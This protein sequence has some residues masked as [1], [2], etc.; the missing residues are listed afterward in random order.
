MFVNRTHGVVATT[1]SV[2]ALAACA[3]PEQ[4]T[5]LRPEGPPDVLAVLVMT[6]AAGQLHEE[7]TYCKLNDP[8]RP[9]LVGRPDATTAQ[10]CPED[11]GAATEV[12]NAY[13][14]GWYVR[15]MFDELL[16]PEIEELIEL[17]DADGNPSG[18]FEG[19]LANTQ[20]VRLQ[21]QTSATGGA[22]VDVP[23]DG[24][25][26]PSG[27]NITWPLGPSLV[28]KP[29]NPTLVATGRECQV[30][31]RAGVIDQ[32]GVEVPADQL[33]PYK[34]KIAPVQVIA[35]DPADDPDL[36]G[37]VDATQLWYDN[38]YVHFNTLV[39][40][41]SLCPDAD[42]DGYCD[43]DS[44]FAFKDVEHPTEGPGL[45]N[46]TGET[47][48]QLTDCPGGMGDTLCGKGH[49]SDGTTACNTAADC[50]SGEVCSTT[51]AYSLKPYG[52]TDTEF[53]FGPLYPLQT[54][55][56]YTFGFAPGAKVKD[57]C[58][59]ETALTSTAA[60]MTLAKFKTN[61]FL[62]RKANIATG[63]TAAPTKKLVLSFSNVLR[64]ADV[65]GPALAA[66]GALADTDWELSP[67]PFGPDGVTAL[68]KAQIAVSDPGF[69][70]QA[71]F[72]GH[73]KTAT[74]YT[75]T[76]KAGVKVRDWYGKEYTNANELKITWKTA[77]TITATFT[78][79]NTVLTKPAPSGPASAVGVSLTFNQSMIPASLDTTEYTV[80]DS[81]G[82]AVTGFT[83]A[84]GTIGPTSCSTFGTGCRLTVA[85][86]AL[87][88]GKYKFTLKAGAEILDPFGAKYTQAA[89]KV[90][91]FEVKEATPVTPIK[92][93]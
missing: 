21:C 78:A 58:G 62:Y 4:N 68:T 70:G 50:A 16:D 87:P 61:P 38:A 90:I 36:K 45:C 28:I 23:Y 20:P 35:M 83:T 81:T 75:F 67:L 44:V 14:D 72:R 15:L 39:D 1:L 54:E 93:L 57:R 9:S 12:A 56:A 60:D 74:D 46:T 6:D 59:A 5:D 32:Q 92:C 53:G 33:G 34:F 55:R 19:S 41:A 88:A 43:N 26:S 79:D 69:S 84:A 18:T 73:F 86:A 63:E 40:L 27:N 29:L 85:K 47:C 17:P 76:L 13:P 80:T 22:L 25:Y 3:D 7:A 77:A 11:G 8:K 31:L 24:Y 91:N 64:G 71:F 65:P 89:D 10:V 52:F 37:P 51:Y 82:A 49:C 48:G 2:L 30:T 42:D 66:T